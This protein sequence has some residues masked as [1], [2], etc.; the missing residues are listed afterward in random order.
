MN[1][2]QTLH[3][4]NLIKWTAL[5]KEQA[6]SG[7]TIKEFCARHD[8]SFYAYSYWKHIAKEAY[9]ESLLPEIVPIAPLKA[10]PCSAC[11]PDTSAL[12]SSN[13]HDSNTLI[14]LPLTNPVS[15]SVNDIK[16]DIGASASDE[17]ISKIIKAVRYA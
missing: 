4:A 1:T 14:P 10:D 9:V 5:F 6:E 12:N 2:K 13:S 15:I 11:L 3:Q 7:L 17:L 16:I 8:L